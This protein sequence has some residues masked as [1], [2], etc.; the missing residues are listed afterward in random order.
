MTEAKPKP[1]S[2]RPNQIEDAKSV[3]CNPCCW[4]HPGEIE[5]WSE[6]P[7]SDHHYDYMFLSERRFVKY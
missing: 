5:Q 2:A 4:D 1:E 7:R 3:F 6:E